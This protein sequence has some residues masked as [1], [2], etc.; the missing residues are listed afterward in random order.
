MVYVSIHDCYPLELEFHCHC[1]FT[2][3]VHVRWWFSSSNCLNCVQCFFRLF[4]GRLVDQK[5]NQLQKTEVIDMIKFGANYI[6]RSKESTI[7][8]EDIDE[9]LARGEQKTSELNEKYAK[10]GESNLRQLRFDTE[11]EGPDSV[12]I[13]D[14]E[15]YRTKQ[16][17]SGAL[18]VSFLPMVGSL[19]LPFT[20]HQPYSFDGFLA[21]T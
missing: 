12:Y 2:G 3:C 8:D 13:F 19:S 1:F 11:E 20:Q 14:G 5:S 10:M 6:F 7:K 21:S 18:A 9:I 17:N 16:Q 4:V 15:D